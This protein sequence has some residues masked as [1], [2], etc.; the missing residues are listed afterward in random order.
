MKKTIITTF[1]I[2]IGIGVYAQSWTGTQYTQAKGL[3]ADSAMRAPRVDTVWKGGA[4]DSVGA[5]VYRTVDS[6]LYFKRSSGW[7]SFAIGGNLSAYWDS[8]TTKTSFPIDT[9]P[10]IA[11]M[12]AYEGKAKM[13]FVS[14]TI[15]G[16]LFNAVLTGVDNGG[17]CFEGVSTFWR[18]AD[19]NKVFDVKWWGAKGDYDLTTGTDDA[20]A[21]QACINYLASIKTSAFRPTLYFP[22]SR[23]YRIASP[24]TIPAGIDVVMDG[25]TLVYNGSN[26]A[27]AV[28]IGTPGEINNYGA[29]TIRL[30]QRSIPTWA[31]PQ[32]TSNYGVKIINAQNCKINIPYVL[33]FCNNI[34]F[35]GDNTGGSNG[36]FSYNDIFIGTSLDAVHHLTLNATGTLGWVNEN[37]FNA[38]NFQNSSSTSA[39]TQS[40]YGITIKSSSTYIPNNNIFYK[41]AFQLGYSSIP[42]PAADSAIGIFIDK[43]NAN[44][45]YDIRSENS[46]PIMMVT[47]NLSFG[48]YAYANIFDVDN[49]NQLVDLSSSRNNYVVSPDA[50]FSGV[51]SGAVQI[52]NSGFLPDKINKYDANNYYVQGVSWT[53]VADGNVYP[54]G[55]VGTITNNYITLGEYD[56]MGVFVSTEVAKKFAIKWDVV[57]EKGGRVFVRLYDGAGNIITPTST[58][59]SPSSL[60][61]NIVSTFGGGYVVGSD[62]NGRYFYFG[63]DTSVKKIYVAI[64]GGTDSLKVKSWQLYSLDNLTA[65]VSSGLN[66][67]YGAFGVAAVQ[68]TEVKP[69]GTIIY[70][71]LSISSTPYSW[72]NV[73]GGNTWNIVG[74]SAF[75]LN[76]TTAQAANF[77]ITGNGVLGGSVIAAG[78]TFDAVTSGIVW[79]PR[80]NSGQDAG[81]LYLDGGNSS[82]AIGSSIVLRGGTYASTPGAMSFHT[83][84]GTGSLQPERM[85][86]DAAGKVGI[87]TTT[88][89]APL[90]VVGKIKTNDTTEAKVFHLAGT[91]GHLYVN[92][93]GIGPN[94][95]VRFST[96]GKAIYFTTN[97]TDFPLRIAST[98]I[99]QSNG[100]AANFTEL[101]ASGNLKEQLG[102]ITSD[103][104]IDG[105]I[106]F[107]NTA[108]TGNPVVTLPASPAHGRIIRL[109]NAPA[110]ASNYC[111]WTPA[112]HLDGTTDVSSFNDPALGGTSCITLQYSSVSPGGW[113]IVSH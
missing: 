40:R 27:G 21:I 104:T 34:I 25:S 62:R 31:E 67:Q 108:T 50:K 7:V 110:N 79:T 10:T 11:D 24:I 3:I 99:D 76:T 41:P 60:S 109:I 74:S 77:N 17:T 56:R 78:G 91:Q 73:D 64:G 92:D 51:E 81:L 22:G 71:D 33:G 69:K 102:I 86:I 45:F 113:W 85:R 42:D 106:T 58:L 103:V 88:P 68:P 6:T 107:I 4:K 57:D 101:Y 2:L 87:G 29:I 83:G 111:T 49:K 48:N 75:V 89:T 26:T 37:K 95:I 20:G 84:T 39:R 18:R 63:V 15:Q 105:G 43:G 97:G 93:E 61:G 98:G 30:R 55:K 53:R 112:A 35:E 100:M 80:V 32:L 70:N 36:G 14:D 72:Q 59:I 82:G 5:I 8:T 28:T 44:N 65:A 54:A 47:K 1:L 13:V 23:Y 9:V 46:G 96:N 38:G 66:N 16:G 94:N 52:F 12:E 90:D 19:E